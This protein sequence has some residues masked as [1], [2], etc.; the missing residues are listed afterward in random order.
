[1]A[2]QMAHTLRPGNAGPLSMIVFPEGAS[3][4]CKF[5]AIDSSIPMRHKT[6]DLGCTEAIYFLSG[7]GGLVADNWPT[8][9]FS[10]QY[11]PMCGSEPVSVP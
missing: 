5:Q 8:V 9:S 7:I 3:D 1:M 2:T 11:L 6:D 10:N 4:I